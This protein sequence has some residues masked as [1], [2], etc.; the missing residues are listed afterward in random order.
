[1]DQI[2]P[3]LCFTTRPINVRKVRET[4]LLLRALVAPDSLAGHFGVGLPCWLN[5]QVEHDLSRAQ[6]LVR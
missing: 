4:G 2:D 5:L 1:M 6:I 3:Y